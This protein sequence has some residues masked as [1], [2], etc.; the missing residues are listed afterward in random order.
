MEGYIIF[1]YILKIKDVLR[2]FSLSIFF[3]ETTIEKVELGIE[4][5]SLVFIIVKELVI[6]YFVISNYRFSLLRYS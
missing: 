6:K 1:F 5:W 2:F 4:K 3:K